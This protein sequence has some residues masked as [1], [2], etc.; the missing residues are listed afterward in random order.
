[1]IVSFDELYYAYK[2]CKKNKSNNINALKFQLRLIDNLWQ[3]Y[4]E[5]NSLSYQPSSYIC[6]LVQTPKMREVFASNFRDRVVHHLVVNDLESIFEPIFIHDSYSCRV[7]KGTHKAVQRAQNFTRKENSKFYMQLDIKNF[8]LSIDKNILY[9]RIEEIAVKKSLKNIDRVLYLSKQII[10]DRPNEKFIF[11]GDFKK[12]KNLPQHK[13]LLY[14]SP[15]K[16]LPIGN[17]TSQF[18]ANV[19]LDMMDNYIKEF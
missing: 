8:F 18:F 12:H 13:S 11:R 15:N 14:T 1:M 16:G 3:L 5:I 6:F 19:Y 7:G 17:L 4:E 9:R 2:K 10:F